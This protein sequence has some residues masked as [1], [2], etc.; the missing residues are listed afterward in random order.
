MHKVV[1]SH[2][3]KPYRVADKQ[4]PKRSLSPRD[5]ILVQV[6]VPVKLRCGLTNKV[7]VELFDCV[8][9]ESEVYEL[10]K[11]WIPFMAE[12]L[13]PILPNPGRADVKAHSPS[14]FQSRPEYQSTRII[15]DCSEFEVERPCVL[16]LNAMFYSDYERKASR[17]ARRQSALV[18]LI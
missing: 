4:H 12:R 17:S 5:E 10:L 14:N 6:V 15:L 1:L 9:S 13:E 2:G 16:S 11:T 3:S 18:G 8:S 7:L